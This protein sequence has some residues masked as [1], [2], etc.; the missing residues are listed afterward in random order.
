MTVEVIR[1]PKA[2]KIY[3]SCGALLRYNRSDIKNKMVSSEGSY[4]FN[5]TNVHYIVC[6]SC[7]NDLILRKE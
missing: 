4:M 7:K 2:L 3:C 6:P 1:T 5:M